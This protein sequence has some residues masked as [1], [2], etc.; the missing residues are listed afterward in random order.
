M[1]KIDI[2]EMKKIQLEVLLDVVSF[3]EQEK[4]RYFLCGG[5]LLGAVRHKGFIPW[6]D[7]IDI[8][9][10]RP[11]YNR[12][13]REYSHAF[14]EVHCW[15]TEN[16]FICTY[17]KVSDSRTILTENANLGIQIG[18][19]IDIFPVD[20]LPKGK[21]ENIK[22]VKEM[23]LLKGLVICASAK[24]ISKRK[25]TKKIEITIIRLFY[26][27]FNIQSWLTGYAIR[28]AQKYPFDAS[29][30]VGVLVW[31]YG[32]KEIMKKSIACEYVKGNFEGRRM[33]ILKNYDEY[34]FNLYGDYMKLPPEKDRIYKHGSKA[35]WITDN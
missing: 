26:K 13:I 23:K 8:S 30:Y 17:A 19:N 4:I 10:P 31:G 5:T 16:E 15:D 1:K 2:E 34:L 33:N 6:D 24:D 29:E 20:G 27:L 11:D 7:D 25:N 28:L 18:I 14:Y 9:M 21:F 12:F 35:E 32:E 22:F 3:C